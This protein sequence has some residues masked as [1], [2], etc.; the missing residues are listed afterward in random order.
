MDVL[1]VVVFYFGVFR[2]KDD[3]GFEDDEGECGVV[4]G[5]FFDIGIHGEG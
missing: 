5:W 2:A 4:F 3:V 1:V